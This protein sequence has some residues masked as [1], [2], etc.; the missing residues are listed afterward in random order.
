[1]P[2]D[3]RKAHQENDLAAMT[4]PVCPEVCNNERKPLESADQINWQQYFA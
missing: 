2:Q 4:D 3:L 1:M